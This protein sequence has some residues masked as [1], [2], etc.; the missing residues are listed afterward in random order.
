MRARFAPRLPRACDSPRGGGL[1]QPGHTLSGSPRDPGAGDVDSQGDLQQ[2][3]LK[4]FF[5]IVRT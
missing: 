5:L 3:G 1:R 4:K 2:L